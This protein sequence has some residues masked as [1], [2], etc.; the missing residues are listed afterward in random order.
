[1]RKYILNCKDHNQMITEDEAIQNAL[2]QEKEGIKPS[3][4]WYDSRRKETVGRPGWLVWSTWADGCG[5]VY[6]RDDGKMI[7]ATGWQGDF[8]QA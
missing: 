3:F 6:R 8:C 1:M 7:L 5:V 2:D 4:I